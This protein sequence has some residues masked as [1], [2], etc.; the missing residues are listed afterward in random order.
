MLF[1]WKISVGEG[2][3]SKIQSICEIVYGLLTVVWQYMHIKK[4]LF[5]TQF[6]GSLL[7]QCIGKVFSSPW[8]IKKKLNWQYD[9]SK[10]YKYFK[11]SLPYN[12]F[13]RNLRQH[14]FYIWKGSIKV[15]LGLFEPWRKDGFLHGFG[16]KKTVTDSQRRNTLYKLLLFQ[17]ELDIF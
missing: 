15:F 6:R 3:K 8:R 12:S 1:L 7:C 4:Q 10:M 17:R 14:V 5:N 16:R 13:S 2:I 9:F 11:V